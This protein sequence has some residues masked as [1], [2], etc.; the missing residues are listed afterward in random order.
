MG[1]FMSGGLFTLA[2]D[3]H[4]KGEALAW[5]VFAGIAFVGWLGTLFIR[6]RGL[7]SAEW[8][9]SEDG[10]DEGDEERS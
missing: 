3:V 5:G 10:T 4:P 8:Q 9:G 2:V 6:N 1:P 7:E